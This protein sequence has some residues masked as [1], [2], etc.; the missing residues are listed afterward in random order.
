M[1][2][3]NPME[4]M[5]REHLQNG[6]LNLYIARTAAGPVQHRGPGRRASPTWPWHACGIDVTV[7][8]D[9]EGRHD[10]ATGLRMFPRAVAWSAAHSSTPP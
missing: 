1:S 5:E 8:Y 4:I 3:I 7:D 6:E 9:S 2:E 10:L